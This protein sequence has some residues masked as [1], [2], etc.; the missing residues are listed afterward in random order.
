MLKRSP[1]N[2]KVDDE[3]ELNE[4]GLPKRIRGAIKLTEEQ[5]RQ[6]EACRARQSELLKEPAWP[7]RQKMALEARAM[8][9]FGTSITFVK[10]FQDLKKDTVFPIILKHFRGHTPPNPTLRD[11]GRSLG[12]KFS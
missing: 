12:G 7:E 3:E 8:S 1:H 10:S 6:N 11:I 4:Y 2:D 5:I 9:R